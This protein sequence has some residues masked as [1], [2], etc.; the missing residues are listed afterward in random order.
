MVSVYEH[1]GAW[2][3]YYRDAGK[4]IRKKVALNEDEARRAAAQINAQ[5]SAGVPTF[6][7]FTPI[8]VP[9]LQQQF[10]DHH[11]HARGSTLATVNRYRTATVKCAFDYARRIERGGFTEP[12]RALT[13]RPLER[14]LPSGPAF[15]RQCREDRI[16]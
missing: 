8:S 7:S 3:L 15:S 10:L 16:A 13:E 2:W 4:P 6:L 9:E 12:Y 11:E 1:H 14:S 5:L